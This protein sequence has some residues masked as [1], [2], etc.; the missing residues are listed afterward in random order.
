MRSALATIRTDSA[1][2]RLALSQQ[3]NI[4][5]IPHDNRNVRLYDLNGSRLGRLPR[6]SRRGHRRMVCAAAWADDNPHCNLFTCGF[7][8]QLLAWKVATSFG[9]G[10]KD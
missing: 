4:I 7:D 2:N 1:V 5:A 6:S 9:K 8:K 3:H 10:E